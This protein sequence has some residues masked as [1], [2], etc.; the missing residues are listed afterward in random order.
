MAEEISCRFP[1]CWE[2][3]MFEISSDWFSPGFEPHGHC[4]GD[5]LLWL[6]AGSGSWITFSLSYD[7]HRSGSGYLCKQQTRSCILLDL[8]NVQ[9]FHFACGTTPGLGIWKLQRSRFT[10]WIAVRRR[11]TTGLSFVTAATLWSFREAVA[12][13]SRGELENG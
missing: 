12:L 5:P 9:R 13:A 4:F 10:G 2:K 3:Y 8:F 6:Y 11:V 1:A 7:T